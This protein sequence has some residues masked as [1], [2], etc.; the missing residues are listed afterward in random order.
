MALVCAS[1]R[2][3]VGREIST[4]LLSMAAISVA[5]VV[6]ERT[7]HLYCTPTDPARRYD[8]RDRRRTAWPGT[9]RGPLEVCIT[10]VAALREGQPRGV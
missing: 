6:F 5:T 10:A 8:G 9:A 2:P 7:S 4:M 1:S 3:I